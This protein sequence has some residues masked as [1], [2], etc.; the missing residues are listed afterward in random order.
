MKTFMVNFFGRFAVRPRFVASAAALGMGACSAL[1]ADVVYTNNSYLDVLPPVDAITFIN[2]GT[3]ENIATRLPAEFSN[4]KNITN[5]GVMS[6]MPGW[7]FNDVDSGTGARKLAANFHNDN[8]NQ[9]PARGLVE[10]NDG[11]PP[12]QLVYPSDPS[13]LWI[14]ATNIV[15][16]GV[17]RV[18]ANG[19]LRLVGTNI[20]LSRGA[21]EVSAIVGQ[22]SPTGP[23]VFLPD[24]SILDRYWN[25]GVRDINTA[26]LWDGLQATALGPPQFRMLNPIA[27][28]YSNVV[29]GMRGGAVLTV[30]NMATN[31]TLFTT[32]VFVPTN[33]VKQ[34]VFVAIPPNSSNITARISF[35][36]SSWPTNPM[37]AAAVQITHY[38]TNI[39]S[40]ALEAN[41][42][43]FY[44]IL[45]SETNRDLSVNQQG[46][47]TARPA[48]YIVSRVPQMMT[49]IAPSGYPDTRFL[50]DATTFSNSVGV[51]APWSGYV[52][53]VA[54]V[55][56]E[57]TAI[58]AGSFTNVPGRVEIIGDSVNLS[59]ARIRGEGYIKINAKH[60]VSTD[61]TALDCQS[62][63]LTLGSTNGNL[64]V[65]NLAKQNTARTRGYLYAWSA[66]WNN[67]QT[68]LTD[69]YVVS[70]ND[71]GENVTNNV[72]ITNTVAIA[73]HCLMLDAR[74]L[75]DQIPVLVYDLNTHGQNVQLN[76]NMTVAESFFVDATNLTVN[77]NVVLTN[78]YYQ[79]SL[80][81]TR[82]V[83][84]PDWSHTN[85]PNLALL[86]NNGSLTVSNQVHFGDDTARPYLAFVNKGTV[87]G[88]SIT[89]NSDYFQNSGALSAESTLSIK[90]KD[91]ALTGGSSVSG[92]GTTI[93]CG[94]L[95][96][97]G[98]LLSANG[99]LEL[100]VT[101]ALFDAGGGSG[102]ALTLLN[103][104][105]QDRKPASGDLLGTEINTKA[106]NY[107]E[108]QHVWAAENRG[109]VAAGY[110]NNSAV[111][112]LVCSVGT[113]A[114]LLSFSGLGANN[115]LYVDQLDL[116]ALGQNYQAYL[117]IAP[118]FM[119]YYASAKVGFTPPGN[120]T[121][122]EYLNNQFDG[123]LQ[124]VKDFAGPNSSV[125][126]VSNG[127]SII[128]N[129][130]LR[131]SRVIDSDN[132]GL[133]NY[134]DSYPLG[135]S[136]TVSGTNTLVGANLVNTGT[137]GTHAFAI[138]WSAA[139]NSVYQIDYRS[140]LMAGVWEKLTLFTNAA[141]MTRTVTVY[142]TNAP[143]MAPQR[144]Y[145]VGLMR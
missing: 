70:T 43:Y 10:A 65:A 5:N 25:A 1:A 125:D 66:L 120:L 143:A 91:G 14:D 107:A 85:A 82:I 140:N 17:L 63:S 109:A 75:L 128:M 64:T 104:I 20:N 95:K 79:N 29:D 71:A 92:N 76:D 135:G 81:Q 80:G 3:I 123:R 38:T 112:K 106:D 42:I 41:S 116:T 9:S 103:G 69:N 83:G 126:V 18:G 113:G 88:D 31:G 16:K 13:Y 21:L 132:D 130:A 40:G 78:F 94:T 124:W 67:S 86:T 133:P 137:A 138:T 90:G 139:P 7:Y 145:R 77:G 115:A 134:F 26:G 99:V 74:R 117:D 93:S 62:L 100:N 39:V 53:E 111:G 50:Y 15:N 32:N 110:Q 131:D 68:V 49:G 2:N 11:Y 87:N 35:G 46:G 37:V 55:T 101:N 27:N 84:V 45:A 119:L 96:L 51:A 36:P 98:Y 61:F 52:A 47:N 4:T 144:F 8:Y 127:V 56:A 22:G 118:D 58:P 30:T 114:P 73:M 57:P 19:W 89:L 97:N 108:V 122:E 44:D 12:T 23:G 105:R 59:R 28:T 129:R 24:V 60:V 72:P 141:G 136:G 6:A 34:A 33:I 48:N 102:N 121:P 142:D 54:N